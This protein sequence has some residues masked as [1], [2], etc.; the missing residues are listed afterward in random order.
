MKIDFGIGV[1]GAS[2]SFGGVTA[3]RN[4]GGAYFRRKGNPTNPR[5]TGQ[6]TQRAQLA[7]LTA[8]WKGLTAVQQQAWKSASESGQFTKTDRL[9]KSRPLSASQLYT[10]L[11]LTLL[12]SG[13]AAITTPPVNLPTVPN[14]V[15]DGAATQAN[16]GLVL[17]FTGNAETGLPATLRANIYATEPLSGGILSPGAGAYRKIATLQAAD[18]DGVE[19]DAAT[20]YAAFYGAAPTT[21]QNVGF[22]VEYVFQGV[23]LKYPAGGCVFR[24]TSV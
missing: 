21:A 19:Y 16:T 4:K 11:N 22:R 8:A 18:F 10:S 9:G 2:G 1:A 6:Q 12:A 24:Y 13:L 20:D 15:L 7:N 23:G 3:S 17:T 5:S 14:I